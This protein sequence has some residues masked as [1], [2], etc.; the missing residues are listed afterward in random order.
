MAIIMGAVRIGEAACHT[1][2]TPELCVMT[3]Q[4]HVLSATNCGM[5]RAGRA[6]QLDG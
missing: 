4:A 5:L 6:A 3:H 1:S 2:P